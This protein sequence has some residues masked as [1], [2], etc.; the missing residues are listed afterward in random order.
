MVAV[1]TIMSFVCISTVDSTSPN[2]VRLL[3]GVDVEMAGPEEALER[4]K[5]ARFDAVTVHLP[6][7][8]WDAEDLLEQIHRT[9]ALVPVIICDPEGTMADA[10][11]FTK[12][13]AFYFTKGEDPDEF[14]QILQWACEFSQL[15][16][17]A[18]MGN[19][20]SSEPWRKFLVG[21]SRAMQQLM[22]MIRLV[23]KRRSTV[24]ISGETG[25][26]KEMVARAIHLTSDRGSL[27]MVAVNCT[28]LP[29]NLLEAELFGH[30]KGAFTGAISH[31]AGR[32]EQAH[33]STLFLDEVGD[34][35][36]DIQAKLLRVLQEREF[37]RIGSSE[38]IKV[39]VRMIAA[40]NIDLEQAVRD[41]KFR[42]D[43]FYRLNVVPLRVPALRE[44]PSDIPILVQ[45]LNE[46]IC[47]QEGL[48]P[49]R[50][51]RETL[52]RLSHYSWP[53]NVR[54]LENAVE[55]AIALSGDRDMLYPAD[56]PLPPA[57]RVESRAP[58][59]W[60]AI[61]LPDEGLDLTQIVADMERTILEQALR[62]TGGNKAQAAGMLR[63]KRTTLSAK[64]R[65]LSAAR[66]A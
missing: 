24:L 45:H 62:K 7:E 30:V 46:K 48:K 32:F 4:L 34:L 37:Q 26:G 53:G 23:G 51:A 19:A 10:V 47:T 27:P 58:T 63:L 60:P 8:Q 49:R 35:P 18:A 41:G 33:R 6:L 20:V 17:L 36:L 1:A 56:F 13:G 39:D 38:T 12:L 52:E 50:L 43:L 59:A 42:E 54:Q 11:R 15:R 40:S 3:D 61:A 65:S 64:L 44:R 5:G 55:M 9:Q 21:E 22:Q 66:I 31:R 57:P 16:D 14:K 28:A 25:A 29:E 2:L